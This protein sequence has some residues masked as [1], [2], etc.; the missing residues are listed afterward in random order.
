MKSDKYKP[1]SHT[2]SW[3]TRNKDNLQLQAG[4]LFD[5]VI[6]LKFITSE[7]VTI[8]E[9]GNR[10]EKYVD[11]FVLRS[12][13]ELVDKKFVA[14]VANG[15]VSYSQ[16]KKISCIRK[17]R[18]KPS[19]K[20]QY[21]QVAGNTMI[22]LDIFVQNFFMLDSEGKTLMSFSNAKGRLASVEIQMGYFGQFSDFFKGNEN[23]V[24]TLEQYFDFTVKP[25]GVQTITCNV[26]YCQTDKLPPDSTMHI[27]GFVGSCYTQ[28][29]TDKMTTDDNQISS[30]EL[31]TVDTSSV[32]MYQ[33]GENAFRFKSFAH[34]LYN[35][36]TRRFFRNKIPATNIKEVKNLK[37]KFKEGGVCLD[38]D[39]SLK[40]G[41]IV[42]LSEG[43]VGDGKSNV[44]LGK[45][46]MYGSDGKPL[47]GKKSSEFTKELSGDTPMRALNSFSSFQSGLLRVQ[48]L[49]NGCYLMFL[50][51]EM[52]HSEKLSEMYWY[53][54][55]P[56]LGKN[57]VDLDGDGEVKASELGLVKC[58]Y[59]EILRYVNDSL[60]G[61]AK[62]MNFFDYINS[63]KSKNIKVKDIKR[64][65]A[66][67]NIA[68]DKALCTI[69]C[70]FFYFLTPF[71]KFYF[72]S[73]YAVSSM[74]AYFL[75]QEN[76]EMEFTMIWQ[77]VSFATVENI[78]DVQICCVPT[79]CVPTEAK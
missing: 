54:F 67:Y 68:Y 41:V 72:A 9:G 28:P 30:I 55:D 52:K 14:N 29:V 31:S 59:D 3:A 71:Q 56:R 13:Y 21:K 66:V 34:Y 19:I 61:K 77:S 32:Y 2:V 40:Y 60:G 46:Q 53:T 17:C 38:D 64:I 33:K 49:D 76:K 22:E 50:N 26:T 47:K 35:N 51:E 42:F 48:P 62:N 43:I 16:D 70:P 23:G 15:T 20:V 8:K 24:P 74:I 4:D 5:R 39:S 11:E 73:R 7:Q 37:I 75:D 45:Q 69:T 25:E 79:G 10:V 57:G 78:N 65:P 63:L 36:I 27:H 1:A 58:T 6:N 18:L 12:D 44:F